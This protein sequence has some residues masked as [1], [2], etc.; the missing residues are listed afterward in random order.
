MVVI[1]IRE[2]EEGVPARGLGGEGGNEGHVLVP[3]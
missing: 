2:H 1:N 3:G